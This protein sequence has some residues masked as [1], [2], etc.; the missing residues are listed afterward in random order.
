[1]LIVSVYSS[2]S[3]KE[4]FYLRAISTLPNSLIMLLGVGRFE[5]CSHFLQENATF[6]QTLAH[7][8]IQGTVKEKFHS[9]LKS[10][11]DLNWVGK[12]IAAIAHEWAAIFGC[13]PLSLFF[14][15]NPHS[16]CYILP[17]HCH[18]C[19]FKTINIVHNTLC[20]KGTQE[21]LINHKVGISNSQ[22]ILP[23][24]VRM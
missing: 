5:K 14:F 16:I 24:A 11:V 12:A 18:P 19:A 7:M 4:T 6:R 3:A 8:E 10:P 17:P 1:M 22:H 13:N 9:S 21:P 23:W 15:F 20:H 2:D